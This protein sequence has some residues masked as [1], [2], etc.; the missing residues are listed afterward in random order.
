MEPARQYELLRRIGAHHAAGTADAR[1]EARAFSVRVYTDEAQLRGE[2]ETL[3][4]RFP[5]LVG[6]TAQLKNPGDYLTHDASGMPILVCRQEDG[7]LKA[8]QNTCRHRG[9]RIAPG[10]TGHVERVFI[11]PYHAWTYGSDGKL[12]GQP[13]AAHFAAVDNAH[14]GLID[15]QVYER[16]GMVFVLPEIS[17]AG[18]ADVDFEA[19]FG[20]YA[21]ELVSFGLS[22]WEVY[23]SRTVETKFNWKMMIEAN[24]EGYHIS[25]LHRDTAGPRYMP[26]LSLGDTQ[27]PH[28]RIAL[29]YRHFT[30]A[31]LEVAP[32]A[33]KILP[34]ADVVYFLFP[35]T[36]VL[37]SAVSANILTVFPNGPHATV[38]KAATLVP[39]GTTERYL[40]PLYK[41]YWA[42]I[43]EDIIVSEPIQASARANGDLKL[44]FGANEFLLS[45]FHDSIAGALR[46]ELTVTACDG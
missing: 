36:L 1:G 32:E 39:P 13:C 40:R 10:P 30:P 7:S 44:W 2:R 5:I 21:R 18:A 17:T 3:F 20:E 31:A 45:H 42:T 34:F 38:V 22:D 26:Q 14:S 4:R 29:V 43:D 8:F 46:G 12:H 41:R 15:L 24:R 33:A 19:W 23:D 37:L 27:G 35:N 11:C 6:F 25:M 28:S 9:A 16:A